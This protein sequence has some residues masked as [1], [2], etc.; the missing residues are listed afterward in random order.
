MLN[1]KQ[2]TDRLTEIFGDAFERAAKDV[3]RRARQT[4]TDVVIW[5]GE[6]IVEVSPDQIA[7][8]SSKPEQG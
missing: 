5:E 4:G 2:E 7:Q 3:I 6:E 8:E 1:R